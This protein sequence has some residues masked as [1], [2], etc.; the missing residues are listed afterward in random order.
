MENDNQS[1]TA[2]HLKFAVVN[3]D[4]Y[5]AKRVL[6]EFNDIVRKK[7]FSLYNPIVF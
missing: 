4:K 3:F 6:K 7:V 5:A 1:A 2:E